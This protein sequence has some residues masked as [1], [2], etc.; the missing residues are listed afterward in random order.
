MPQKPIKWGIK[1]WMLADAKTGLTHNFKVYLGKCGNGD[2]C[3]EVGLATSVVLDLAEP[4][5]IWR[6]ISVKI[7]YSFLHTHKHILQKFNYRNS[8][9]ARNIFVL[10]S[11]C[12][13]YCTHFSFGTFFSFDTFFVWHFFHLA[14]FSFGTLFS[15]DTFFI[16]HF[17]HLALFS[18][19]T[20]FVWHFFHLALFSFDTFFVW[21]SFHLV[22]FSFG[23]FFIWHKFELYYFGEITAPFLLLLLISDTFLFG[24]NLLFNT[25][26]Q[27]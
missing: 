18:F 3:R 27:L 12:R 24:R 2:S 5:N 6:N 14:L 8:M 16:W 17:F 13:N 21:H 22:L 20:F 4:Y 25:F 11:L 23:T 10:L 19:D 9:R 7:M 15:F 1:V 26:F